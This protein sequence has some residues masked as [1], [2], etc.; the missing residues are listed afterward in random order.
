M[1]NIQLSKEGVLV[2]EV[3]DGKQETILASGLILSTETE[4]DIYHEVVAVGFEV[5]DIQVGDILRVK[6]SYGEKLD[7]NFQEYLYFSHADTCYFYKKI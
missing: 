1:E 3:K 4:K 7:I 2:K 6:E 5:K